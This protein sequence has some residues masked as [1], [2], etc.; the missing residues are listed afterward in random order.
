[1]PS[2][3]LVFTAVDENEICDSIALKRSLLIS[4]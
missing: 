2:I 1:M 3:T 4:V